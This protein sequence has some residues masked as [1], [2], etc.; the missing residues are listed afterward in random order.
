MTERKQQTC[1]CSSCGC[2]EPATRLEEETGDPMCEACCEYAVADDGEI[3]CSRRPE[4]EDA[5]EWTGGGM[6][7]GSTHWVSRPRARR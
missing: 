4:Y 2:S 1:T 3:V 7:G 5:G 6:M